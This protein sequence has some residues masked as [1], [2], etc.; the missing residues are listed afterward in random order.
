MRDESLSLYIST[1]LAICSSVDNYDGNIINI[2]PNFVI[3]RKDLNKDE[4]GKDKKL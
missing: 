3:K 1:L 2:E 4:F